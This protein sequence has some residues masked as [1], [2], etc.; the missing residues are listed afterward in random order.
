MDPLSDVLSLL[1]PQSYASAGFD[2]GG[3]WSLR[4]PAY[5]GIKCNAVVSGACWLSIDAAADA[6]RL[7]TGD[8]FLLPKGW[9]FRLA[10]DPSVPS[11]D[12]NAVFPPARR[13]GVVTLNGGG[14]FFLVGSRF[15]L[16]GRHA[17]LLLDVLPPV[18]LVRRDEDRDTLR[19]ALERMR[20]ELHDPQPG[21]D[22]VAQHLAQLMLVQVLRLHIAEAA[23]DGIGWL[24]GLGDRRIGAAIGLMHAEP[25]RRWTLAE[26]ADRVGMSRT[27]FAVRFKRTVG[28]A[29]IDY[30]TRWR[31]LLAGDRLANSEEAIPTI[32]ASLG[33]EAESA[34][35]A[36][37]KRVMGCS[38][39]RYGRDRLVAGRA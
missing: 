35:G 39:R 9:P 36:A 26:L 19:W 29:P 20:R 14:D 28:L 16:A 5:E 3:D 4:F 21:A 24:S 8:C 2:A 1:K 17:E 34:F 6:V 33:Y 38:P 27:S 22:M 7:E 37:F 13:G 30:L 25:A 12:A 10:S 31:M 32:A 15:L 18:V 23:R 11:T